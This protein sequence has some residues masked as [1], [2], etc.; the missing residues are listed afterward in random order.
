MVFK[1]KEGSPGNVKH[2]ILRGVE[3]PFGPSDV[4]GINAVT[5]ENATILLRGQVTGTLAPDSKAVEGDQNKPMQPLAR[6]RE[7][8]SPN[9]ANKELTSA[10]TMALPLIF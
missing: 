3:K 7:Y 6:L 2:P 5:P 4:Y 1:G 10:T 8:P 9:G